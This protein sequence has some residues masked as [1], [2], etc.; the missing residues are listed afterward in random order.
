MTEYIPQMCDI[1]AHFPDK[2]KYYQKCM[3]LNIPL[4]KEREKRFNEKSGPRVGDYVLLPNGKYDRF[5]QEYEN[6]DWIQAGGSSESSFYFFPSGG[7]TYSGTL[8]EGYPRKDLILTSE[9][10]DG[11]CWFFDRDRGAANNGVYFRSTFR[12]F[13]L[14]GESYDRI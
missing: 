1:R 14:K 5:T 9:T 10:K 2:E 6:K 4:L 13:R 12:V 3:D 8:N 11:K 7:L